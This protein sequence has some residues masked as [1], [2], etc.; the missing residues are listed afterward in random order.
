MAQRLLVAV[1]AFGIVVLMVALA[2]PAAIDATKDNRT[3]GFELSAGENATVTSGLEIHAESVSA[4]GQEATISLQDTETRRSITH[5][6]PENESEPYHLSDHT[7]NV[8]VQDID[9]NDVAL[10]SVD[11]PPTYGWSESSRTLAGLSDVLLAIL[12]FVLVLGG[13]GAVNRS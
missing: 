4:S 13:L 8:T 9:S 5:T 12:A 3:A 10:V 1:V 6:I 7:M 11:Y 2:L